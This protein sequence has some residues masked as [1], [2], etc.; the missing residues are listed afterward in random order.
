MATFHSALSLPPFVTAL[1]DVWNH[2]RASDLLCPRQ[3]DY[4]NVLQQNSMLFQAEEE[5]SKSLGKEFSGGTTLTFLRR[6][7]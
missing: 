6:V 1:S 2:C 3:P 4:I 7:N 5:A